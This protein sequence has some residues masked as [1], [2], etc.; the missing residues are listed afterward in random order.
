MGSW[1]RYRKNELYPGARGDEPPICTPLQRTSQSDAQGSATHLLF[2]HGEAGDS[3]IVVAASVQMHHAVT[4]G[5]ARVG[6]TLARKQEKPRI[7]LNMFALE[8][9]IVLTTQG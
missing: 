4:K 7:V 6:L 8:G 2:S 5:L 1:G 9:C 3:C